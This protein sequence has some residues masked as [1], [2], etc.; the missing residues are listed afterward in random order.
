MPINTYVFWNNESECP[1]LE[2]YPSVYSIQEELEECIYIGKERFN[3]EYYRSFIRGKDT[4]L[5]P[6]IE[7]I[8]PSP[9]PEKKES[10]RG[11]EVLL[12]SREYLLI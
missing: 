4:I 11:M 8:F 12:W 3:G 2:I 1:I 10:P 5:V 6:D 7:I 9:I